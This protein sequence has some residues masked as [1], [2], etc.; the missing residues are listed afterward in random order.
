MRALMVTALVG[1]V[2]LTGCTVD[3]T[4]GQTTYNKTAI[5][6]LTGAVLAGGITAATTGK[7]RNSHAAM[8]AALGAVVGGA[9]GYLLDQKE[10]QLREQMAGTG[11]GVTRNDDGSVGLVMPGNIT[12]D[13]NAYNV[14]PSFYATLDKVAQTLSDNKTAVVVSGYTDNTGNDGINIPLSQNRANAV[15]NYLVGKGVAQANITAKGYGS[16][17]PVGDNST[18]AG[19]EQNRRVELSI[20]AKQ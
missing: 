8:A 3:P 11:V 16:A 19:K 6:A 4:T 2:A 20:Y 14:K 15:E 10:K 17:N 5:G 9:G 7:H 13:T 18:A 12:F 1:S